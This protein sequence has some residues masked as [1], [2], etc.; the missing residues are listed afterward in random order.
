MPTLSCVANDESDEATKDQAYRNI[1]NSNSSACA[2]TMSDREN[3]IY[4]SFFMCNG[5]E[6]V[7][8]AFDHQ[9]LQS[10][11]DSSAC[12]SLGGVLQNP[13]SPDLLPND[14]SILLR[15]AGA[16]GTGTVTF[17]PTATSDPKSGFTDASIKSNIS[18]KMAIG[19]SISIVVLLAI[20]FFL[21][22]L[23]S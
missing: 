5:T 1:C 23:E 10:G 19:V 4:G 2:G 11:N 13:K 15:Q 20:A 9:Y 6:K 12:T 22:L 7:S 8:W 14:C 17:F 21:V 3:G 18:A 16:E